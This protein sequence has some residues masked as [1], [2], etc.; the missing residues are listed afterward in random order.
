MITV[1]YTRKDVITV[2]PTAATRKDV[3]AVPKR[4]SSFAGSVGDWTSRHGE[5]LLRSNFSSILH[6]VSF[7]SDV[8]SRGR[9]VNKQSIFIKISAPTLAVKNTETQINDNLPAFDKLFDMSGVFFRSDIPS[10]SSLQVALALNTLL[11]ASPY[12]GLKRA[13]TGPTSPNNRVRNGPNR[14]QS[15]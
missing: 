2:H 14:A 11:N 5:P 12:I 15:G 1:N 4:D 7:R 10:S 3:T 13:K 6:T 9:T 8:Q